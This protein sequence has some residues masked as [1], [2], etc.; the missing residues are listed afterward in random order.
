M[1]GEEG[2][3][4]EQA[5]VPPS[6]SLSKAGTANCKRSR[7]FSQAELPTPVLGTVPLAEAGEG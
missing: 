1:V 4:S 2:E 7:G 5:V 3:I 6:L